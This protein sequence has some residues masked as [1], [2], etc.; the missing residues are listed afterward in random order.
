MSGGKESCIDWGEDKEV[1]SWVRIGPCGDSGLE[2]QEGKNPFGGLFF[3]MGDQ[4]CP[5]LGRKLWPLVVTDGFG[6]FMKG[7]L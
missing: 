2:G 4:F 1:W 5:G 6:F 7:F 3:K